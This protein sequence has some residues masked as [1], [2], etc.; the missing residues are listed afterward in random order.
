MSP[1]VRARD[2]RFGIQIGSDCPKWDKSGHF[3]HQFQYI[4]ARR[5]KMYQSVL[6]RI[7][8]CNRFVLFGRSDVILMWKHPWSVSDVTGE[9]R[10]TESNLTMCQGC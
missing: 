5:T 3:S 6:K 2:V 4:L 9:T 1:E 8:K 10:Q 7:L